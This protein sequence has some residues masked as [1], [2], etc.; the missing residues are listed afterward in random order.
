MINSYNNNNRKIKLDDF[1]ALIEMH[2]R[3]EKAPIEDNINKDEVLPAEIIINDTN[4]ILIRQFNWQRNG[5][6]NCWA[7]SNT[8]SNQ[9]DGY[10]LDDRYT[11]ITFVASDFTNC[12]ENYNGY[13]GIVYIGAV[14]SNCASVDNNNNF[15]EILDGTV[16]QLD[17]PRVNP[18][19]IHIVKLP[20]ENYNNSNSQVNTSFFNEDNTLKVIGAVKIDVN[21]YI[22]DTYQYHT[23]AIIDSY[24]A[25]PF[26]AYIFKKNQLKIN[27]GNITDNSSTSTFNSASWDTGDITSL[28]TGTNYVHVDSTGTLYSGT[29]IN[30][31]SDYYL[32]CTVE[33]DGTNITNLIQ[34][35]NQDIILRGGGGSEFDW[36]LFRHGFYKYKGGDDNW[37]ISLREGNVNLMGS[38]SSLT[39]G[40]PFDGSSLDPIHPVANFLLSGTQYFYVHYDRANGS[41]S[42]Q[43]AGA[44][45]GT[46]QT[47]YIDVFFYKFINET[48][49]EVGHTGDINFDLPLG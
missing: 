37:Y 19:K 2:N 40:A 17:N 26:E 29:T 44:K 25:Y 42:W 4:S 33:Y 43:V 48:L 10:N 14:L 18:N 32:I 9:V 15:S 6:D 49:K 47:S 8:Y 24:K 11:Q 7:I 28:S 16:V 31:N 35:Q 46:T 38:I 36:S 3:L 22:V 23:G 41:S 39:P 30:P 27:D 34:N 20:I 12:P 13:D 21:G 45:P 1:N 5:I